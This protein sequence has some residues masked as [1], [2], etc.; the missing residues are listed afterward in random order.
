V[1]N[2]YTTLLSIFDDSI[3]SLDYYKKLN[4]RI[5]DKSKSKRILPPESLADI[6]NTSYEFFSLIED[7][8]DM[9]I[10]SSDYVDRATNHVWNKIAR[11]RREFTSQSQFLPSLPSS[12]VAG[13]MLIL[14]KM[15]PHLNL[16][17]RTESKCASEMNLDGSF[18]YKDHDAS[19]GIMVSAG[20]FYP[21]ITWEVKEVY[22]DKTM[23]CNTI[24]IALTTKA[25]FPH[26]KAEIVTP[27][28]TGNVKSSP[29]LT[30]R[31]LCHAT[32]R[33]YN[34]RVYDKEV[35]LASL[36]AAIAHL[37]VLR[38]DDIMSWE[39]PSY[40]KYLTEKI[41]IETVDQPIVRQFLTDRW[42]A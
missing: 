30:I 6:V 22:I 3:K 42:T 2:D 18:S 35:L 9:R 11:Y 31:N 41:D 19:I 27:S 36:D 29:F 16:I 15:F 1:I 5:L 40:T 28:V 10:S 14:P 24:P 17:V 39:K 12:I 13:L 37:S 38:L 26:S 33:E 7:H 4:C 8:A 23:A 21:L 25:L 32:S 34:D 20:I